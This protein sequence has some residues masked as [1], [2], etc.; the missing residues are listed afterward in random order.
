MIETICG[1]CIGIFD[2]ER[3]WFVFCGCVA[4][5]MGD[6]DGVGLLDVSP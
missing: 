5:V 1:V 6:G 4:F 3:F 2:K